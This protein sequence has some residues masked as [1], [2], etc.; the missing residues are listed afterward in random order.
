MTRHVDPKNLF[1]LPEG[2]DKDAPLPARERP[3]SCLDGS[4]VIN[5]DGTVSRATP[6][7]QQIARPPELRSTK[8][9][10]SGPEIDPAGSAGVRT[11]KGGSGQASILAKL[12]P[13][14]GFEPR[15]PHTDEVLSSNSKPPS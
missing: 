11:K 4:L 6:E 1:G 9:R 12:V 13:Q 14:E 15:P 5:L 2:P 10:I 8:A 3:L 7:Q